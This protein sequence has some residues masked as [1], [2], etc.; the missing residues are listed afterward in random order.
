LGIPQKSFFLNIIEGRITLVAKESPLGPILEEIGKRSGVKIILS[1]AIRSNRVTLDWKAIPLEDG[2]KKLAGSTGL[3][4]KKDENGAIY[5]SE[6]H[7]LPSS[8]EGPG[9][10]DHEGIEP[11]IALASIKPWRG[12]ARRMNKEQLH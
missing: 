9:K 1:P 12:A 7:V 6:V 8:P 4:Y 3:V 11:K 10:V 5:L 2:I